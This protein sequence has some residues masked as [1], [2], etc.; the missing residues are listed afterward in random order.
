M[1]GCLPLA[2]GVI[3]VD[4]AGLF[5]LEEGVGLALGDVHEFVDDLFVL[6]VE[7][8][9]V[10]L[11][12]EV[13]RVVAEAVHLFYRVALKH[14]PGTLLPDRLQALQVPPVFQLP[15]HFVERLGLH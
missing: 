7:V 15:L 2:G 1:W 13:H 9:D 14:P 4:H 8:V 3:V 5:Y 6:V 12:L 10:L 11:R